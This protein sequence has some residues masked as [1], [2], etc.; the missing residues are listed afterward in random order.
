VEAAG[1]ASDTGSIEHPTV[2]RKE[3]DMNTTARRLTT[4][5]LVLASACAAFIALGGAQGSMAEPKVIVMPR[6]EVVGKREAAEPLR[7]VTLPMVEVTGRRPATL[8]AQ[9]SARG[10][11]G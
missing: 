11:R 9:Q 1:G 5:I 2:Q 10:V 6:V 8:V 7:V 3:P 4:T